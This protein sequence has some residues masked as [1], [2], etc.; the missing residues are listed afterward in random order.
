MTRLGQTESADDGDPTRYLIMDH[1]ALQT[2]LRSHT[3]KAI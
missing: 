3:R 2:L 1:V